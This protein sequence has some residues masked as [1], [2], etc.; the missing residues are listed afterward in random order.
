MKQTNN[1]IKFLMAQYR[2]I[3]KNAY[4]KGLTSAVLLTAGLAVAGGV[5][6]ANLTD[7]SWLNSADHEDIVIAGSGAATGSELENLQIRLTPNATTQWNNTVTI[8]GG[9]ASNNSGDDKNYLTLSGDNNAT[10]SGTGSLIIN[11][12]DTTKGLAIASRFGDGNID[13]SI[14][15]ITVENG[16]L[17]AEDVNH[18]KSGSISIA[19]DEITV[20]GNGLD[21]DGKA[22]AII[23]L[24]ATNTSATGTTLT[25]GRAISDSA[26]SRAAS[27]ITVDDGGVVLMSSDDGSGSTMIVG[28]SL[29]VNEGG[30][31]VTQGAGSNKHHCLPYDSG[32]RWLN[33]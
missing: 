6:A 19:A 14:R 30:L 9:E 15:S 18:S 5:Q 3:F 11:G 24:T 2:A 12:E 23:N 13:I 22:T 8:T 28:Q 33:G 4:F 20:G 1:A 27:K 10:L 26:N 29:N 7:A 25:L 21:A 32:R 31:I 16:T 17:L